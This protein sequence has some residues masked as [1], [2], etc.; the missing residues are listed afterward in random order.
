MNEMPMLAFIFTVLCLIFIIN[1]SYLM[2]I[3]LNPKVIIIESDFE[4]RRRLLLPS[5]TPEELFTFDRMLD[6]F[7]TLW[8]K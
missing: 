8:E 7:Y 3:I 5:L 4:K 2:F 6:D 1:I